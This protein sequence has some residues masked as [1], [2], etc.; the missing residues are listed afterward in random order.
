[1]FLAPWADIVVL[2]H[3]AVGVGLKLPASDA[4]TVMGTNQRLS[5]PGR[6]QPYKIA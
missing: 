3:P 5:R 2:M 1:L 4:G 6:R